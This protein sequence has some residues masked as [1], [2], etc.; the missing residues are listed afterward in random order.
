VEWLDDVPRWRQGDA[1][2]AERLREYVMPFVHGALVARLPHHVANQKTPETLDQVMTTPGL[3]KSDAQFVLHAVT[4]ARKLAART[5]VASLQE[6]PNPDSTRS[7]G[8][9]WLERV[10]TLPEEL[11]ERVVW[12][13]VWGVPGP[14]LCEVLALEASVLQ[15]ELEKGVGDT[16][17]PRQSLA[18]AQYLWDLSGE[19][20]TALARA[21][22]YAMSLRFD[23]LE[24]PESAEAAFTAATF[25]DLTDAVVT[26][27]NAR[28]EA[29]PFGDFNPTRV[30]PEP[31]LSPEPRSNGRLAPP[32]AFSADEKTQG[33]FDLPAA[34][35]GLVPKADA[36]P[37]PKSASRPGLPPSPERKREPAPRTSKLFE[38][39][40]PSKKR[41]PAEGRKETVEAPAAPSP[42]QTRVDDDERPSRS[43]LQ[44]RGRVDAETSGRKKNPE[45]EARRVSKPIDTSPDA[46]AVAKSD[47]TPIGRPSE[48]SLEPT[49]PESAPRGRMPVVTERLTPQPVTP[50][51]RYLLIGVV[52]MSLLLAILWRLGLFS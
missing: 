7:E 38:D 23:P 46:P 39:D 45:H 42:A 19:P 31:K 43:K 6:R 26:E 25:Q 34:A 14:E 29:N 18:G 10:R 52:G 51:A 2:A 47:V 32:N 35:R 8:R 40:R 27:A 16:M 21:E 44:V 12:R 3:L 28:P 9:Q 1:A 41:P 36:A 5:R 11:R 30:A 22:T 13:L 37:S 49:D 33:A 15:A 17:S 50:Q 48:P 24:P 4:V 20:S